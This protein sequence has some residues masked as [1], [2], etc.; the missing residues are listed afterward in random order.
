MPTK[1]PEPIVRQ[2]RQMISERMSCAQIA[3]VLG[4]SSSWVYIQKQKMKRRDA[5]CPICGKE[6]KLGNGQ[7]P[8]AGIATYIRK[9]GCSDC[10]INGRAHA[11]GRLT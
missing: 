1:I 11:A 6:W 7:N 4:V 10:F 5:P 2:T 9:N 3:G 8:H